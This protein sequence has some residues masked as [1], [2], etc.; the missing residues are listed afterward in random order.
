MGKALM[1]EGEYTLIMQHLEAALG[2]S[3][4]WMGDHD[5]YAALA[6]AASQ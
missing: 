2:L 4:S 3:L 6:D 1:G 5:V